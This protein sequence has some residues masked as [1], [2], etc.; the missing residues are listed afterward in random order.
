M[1]LPVVQCSVLLCSTLTWLLAIEWQHHYFTATDGAA[2]CAV[3]SSALF[4][5]NMTLC[6]FR[7]I[8]NV[9]NLCCIMTFYCHFCI[10][11]PTPISYNMHICTKITRMQVNE[12]HIHFMSSAVPIMSTNVNKK[13]KQHWTCSYNNAV[14]LKV[15]GGHNSNSNSNISDNQLH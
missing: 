3:L 9:N 6:D 8:L 11:S 2:C 4:H 7:K 12:A 10:S 15:G 13:K 1:V 5:S 14:N